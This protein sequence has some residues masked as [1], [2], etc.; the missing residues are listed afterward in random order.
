MNIKCE[1]CKYL[2]TKG[3]MCDDCRW[4]H[5]D[6]YEELRLSNKDILA[7]LKLIRPK[8]L[9]VSERD[10]LNVIYHEIERREEEDEGED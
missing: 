5:D 9:S 10:T 4:S 7:A 6:Y 2:R 1:T 8:N 3:A